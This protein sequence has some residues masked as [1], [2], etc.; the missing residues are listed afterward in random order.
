MPAITPGGSWTHLGG[1][2]CLW[3]LGLA[4]LVAAGC[5]VQEL[6]RE[7]FEPP[8]VTFQGLTVYQ[9]T[10]KGWPLAANLLLENPNPQPLNLLG[11][12]YQLWIESHNVA[13]GLPRRR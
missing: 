6:A 5:G 8:K 11:Y 12:N 1:R 2:A 13:T 7:R 3:L 9:P 4:V 10:S